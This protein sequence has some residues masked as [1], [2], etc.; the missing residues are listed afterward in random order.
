[1]ALFGDAKIRQMPLPLG[2]VGEVA[3]L[4]LLQPLPGRF[5]QPLVLHV[6]EG[7]LVDPVIGMACPQQLQKIDPALRAAALEPGEE[8]VADVGHITTQA[9]MTGASV[10]D[11]DRARDLEASGEQRRLLGVKALGLLEQQRV[12]LT[13]GDLDTPF[14]QPL[15]QQR[16]SHLAV[17]ML[18][19]DV[20]HQRGTEM[21]TLERGGQP[22]DQGLTLERLPAGQAIANGVGPD[23]EI[24][25]HEV[26]V[27]LE[28]R[29]SGN[30]LLR[31]DD[32]VLVDG[33]LRR[34][35]S[36]PR[37]RRLSLGAPW[38]LLLLL[39]ASLLIELARLEL[40][41]FLLALRHRHLILQPL[42][43]FVLQLNLPCQSLDDP[44]QGLD[45][46]CAF[47]VDDVQ[48]PPRVIEKLPASYR[49]AVRQERSLRDW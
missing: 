24:L 12:E 3:K 25:D 23:E 20:A 4:V 26:P 36:L 6:G 47:L 28:A 19:E 40:R 29:S 32:F 2:L 15:A 18:I 13:R 17:V 38:L 44:E 10:I 31:L 39:L 33:Q 16:L 21:A 30:G 48:P 14:V 8:L 35:G 41:A 42:N 5:R 1:M 43:L 34:L 9:L 45:E 46:R 37:P 11:R 7:F 27:A 49:A 22:S